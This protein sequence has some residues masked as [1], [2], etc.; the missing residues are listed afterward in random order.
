MAR[1]SNSSMKSILR[2]FPA[3]LL[4]TPLGPMR[5]VVTDQGLCDLAFDDDADP[6]QA[7]GFADHPTLDRLRVE[8]G[9]YFVG[10][11]RE[12][13]V[14]LAVQGTD[15]QQSVW[16]ELQRIP[17]GQTASYEDIATRLSKPA[18]VRAVGQANGAN[19]IYLLIPCHRVIAKD[20]TLG[21]YGAGLWR[22]R[23]LL[24]LERTGTLP[25]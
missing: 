11:R 17:A 5:A 13:T 24:E 7:H 10:K 12:F 1:G 8:L 16:R 4:D 25:T 20:G 2:S 18:A 19:R 15:F 14:P 9:E 23:R 3:A 6:A 21:G 22:K